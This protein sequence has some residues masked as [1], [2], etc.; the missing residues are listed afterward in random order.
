MD[1]SEVLSPKRLASAA[2]LLSLMILI[3]RLLGF[4]R[5]SVAGRL[6]N[7]LETDS[8]IAAFNIPDF[9]YYLLVGGA[10][11]AAF[12]PLFTEY[13]AKKDEDNGW[14]MAS[15][16]INL[17]VLILAGLTFL[18]MIFARPLCVL[19]YRFSGTKLDLL[20]LLTRMM[21]PAVFFTAMAGLMGGILNSYQRFFAPALGAI[22]YNVGIISG[23]V[24][25]G[26]RYGISGMAVG[27][28]A[29]AI[30]NFITQ[31]FF[32]A[33]FARG[34]R[35]LYIDLNNPGFRRMIVMFLPVVVGL[36]AT[37][38]NLLIT[39]AM[40][41]GL[42]EGS[43][44]ALRFANR[45]IL[46]PL[47]L[48]A[49]AIST[50]FFPTLSRLA[51]REQW[52]QFKNTLALGVRFIFFITVPAAVAFMV[53]RYPIVRLLFEGQKFSSGDTEMTAY[54]LLFYSLG[55]F[56]HGAINLLPRGFYSLK[57]TVTPV[58]ITIFTVALSIILNLIFLRYTGLKHGGLALSFSI[59]GIANMLLLLFFLYRRLGS[60]KGASMLRA[61]ALSLAAALCMGVVIRFILGPLSSILAG[62]GFTKTLHTL[63]LVA[64]CCGVGFI[65]YIGF[66]LLFSMEELQLLKQ[67][68]KRK[69]RA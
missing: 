11:S 32:V 29:G 12:I 66:A 39:N 69:A 4:I 47:G 23:A 41:S 57:D 54:A 67:M 59:M 50:A 52:D 56:A 49:A 25:L 60:I 33:T 48:F 3:S 43:I 16:F 19:A 27:V 24:L 8:F 26:A 61:F 17:T 20:V 68:L 31:A 35:F 38:L 5:E 40:A 1:S 14:K 21:F 28:V 6:F 13:L 34:Y 53:L 58:L 2:G 9:M 15:T 45:L 55:L 10:L 62:A 7:R 30:A 18:G 46:V 51:A 64:G 44:T 22:I 63:F 65:V 36:S 42:A 37:N